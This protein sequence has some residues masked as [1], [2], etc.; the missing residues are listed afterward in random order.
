MKKKPG[1]LKKI[2]KA[3]FAADGLIFCELFLSK[4]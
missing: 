1:N 4:K 3:F 2:A